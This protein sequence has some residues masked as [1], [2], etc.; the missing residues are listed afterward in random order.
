MSWWEIVLGRLNPGDKI[1]TPGR[2][3]QGLQKKPFSIL[4]KDSLKIIIE[5]GSYPIPLEKLCFDTIEKA[6]HKNPLFWLRV[7][8]LH[9]NEPLENSADKL[10]R[11]ATGSQL[12]RGNYACSILEHC[13]LVRYSIRANRKG[14]E[15]IKQKPSYNKKNG[16]SVHRE[17]TQ[18]Q[19]IHQTK[20]LEIWELIRWYDEVRWNEAETKKMLIP[21][22]VFENLG[23]SERIL[24]HWLAYIT[25]QQRPYQNVWMKG[26]PIFAE[27]VTRYAKDLRHSIALLQNFTM[28]SERTDAVDTFLSKDQLINGE[29]IYYTPRFGMHILSIA[30]TLYLLESFQRDIVKY[31][32]HFWEF[33]IGAEQKSLDDN[34]VSRMAFLLYLLSYDQISRGIVSFHRDQKEILN[35][36]L[37]YERRFNNILSDN[38]KLTS[39]FITWSKRDRYHKRLW[40]ALRDY[41]KPKSSFN[42]VFK[43]ALEGICD[44]KFLAFLENNEAEILE[45]LE[46]PGDIWNLRFTQKIFEGNLQSPKELRNQYEKLKLEHHIMGR[47]YP[48]Q[49]DISFSFS[50]QMCEKMM[51]EYCPFRANSKI[52]EFCLYHKN[53][54]TENK[55]CPVAMITCGYAYYCQPKSC[56]I[57]NG[58]KINFCAGC[59]TS[60]ESAKRDVGSETTYG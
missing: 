60:I 33:I 39:E 41:L 11:E 23:D 29:R 44:K 3:L 56:P 6:F 2:G 40:A 48:E 26:G 31:L 51:E 13:G 52:K 1:F 9:D 30:R 19:P 8:S 5:S 58:S 59:L 15:L 54:A 50:P 18:N 7:A 53:L 43:G 55:L 20:L 34:R 45:S 28:A 16:A 38:K 17:E 35:H 32:S 12:A 14:I 24:V 57:K 4:S 25:D 42:Q 22:P 46:L 49:F 37:S 36:L 21:G 27:V 10:I 47:F